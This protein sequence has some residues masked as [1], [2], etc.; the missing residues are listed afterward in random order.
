MAGGEM[1]VRRV[2]EILDAE[3]RRTMQLLGVR[4]LAELEPGMVQLRA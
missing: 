4:T 1:G 2:V 3:V